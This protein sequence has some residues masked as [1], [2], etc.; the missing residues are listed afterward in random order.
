[1]TKV[2]QWKLWA[3][4]L[5]VYMYRHY[6]YGIFLLPDYVAKIIFVKKLYLIVLKNLVLI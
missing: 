6:K 2:L 4:C 5:Y 3:N 1:M